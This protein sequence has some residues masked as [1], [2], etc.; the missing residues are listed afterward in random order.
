MQA[1]I[2]ASLSRI[3]T[4]VIPVL[5]LAGCFGEGDGPKRIPGTPA[6]PPPEI[7]EGFCDVINFEDVCGPFTFSDFAGGTAGIVD[8]P[9]K[10][11]LNT[12][13]KVAR[14]LKFDPGNGDT[15]GGSTLALDDGVDFTKG[16]AFTMKVWASRS[17][18]VL[19]KLEDAA[20][21]LP[22]LGKERT[23]NHSG[24]GDWEQLCFDFSGGVNGFSSNSITFIFDINVAGDAGGNPDDWTFYFD[25]ITQV[26]SCGGGGVEPVN[27]PVDFEAAPASYDFGVDAGFGGGV[28]TVIANPDQ[29][30]LN[31]T[32]QTARM[33][34]FADQPFGGATLSL[35]GDVDFTS[36]TA[37]RMKVWASR[38]VPVTF[39]FEDA[40]TG[41]PE[42]GIEEVVS[43]SGSGAWEELCF[44]FTGATAGFRTNKITFIFDN[45]VVGDAANNAAAWTFFFDEITQTATCGAAP[46]PPVDGFPTITF[47]DPEVTYTLTDFGG[48]ASELAGDPAGGA[49]QVVQVIKPVG[50]EL[51]AG[52]TVSTLP[53]Q[54]VPVIP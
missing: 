23:A 45:G 31:A 28:A 50:A 29:S 13:D 3:L 39:K 46:P 32:A 37:F 36:G 12:T 25:E 24:S 42:A 9:D 52:T 17:V 11:G 2:P 20:T 54:A 5:F 1:M 53:N 38:S 33:Q 44:D 10:T 30:G 6:P 35:S 48:N 7:P 16:Q 41:L 26:A 47:D 4:C 22:E 8:N 43:H 27:L 34:K 49:N 15:F 51:W 14:M 21:G 19:F 18:P 40:V